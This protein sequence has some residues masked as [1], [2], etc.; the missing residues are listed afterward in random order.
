MHWVIQGEE[1]YTQD[2]KTLAKLSQAKGIQKIY[3][4]AFCLMASQP[5]Q[6]IP[7]YCQKRRLD[8]A[9]VVEEHYLS[10]FK[11]AVF[12]MDS[13]L[14][15][16]ECIDEMAEIMG[17]RDVISTITEKAMNGD[18]PY[19]ESLL[20]RLKALSGLDEALIEKVAQ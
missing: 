20:S 13:T 17:I 12:D 1:I 7:E 6:E 14:I 19:K 15:C 11:L 2:L 10:D 4:T 9:Y 8:C 5:N 3:D 18:I 16:N